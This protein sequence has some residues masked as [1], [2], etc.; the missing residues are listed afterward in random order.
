MDTSLDEI[1]VH[2]TSIVEVFGDYAKAALDFRL[3]GQCYL[4][5]KGDTFKKYWAVVDGNEL[6]FYRYAE[7]SEYKIMHSLARTFV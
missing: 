5:T 6:Y 2:E 1:E 4:K 3:E 7:D